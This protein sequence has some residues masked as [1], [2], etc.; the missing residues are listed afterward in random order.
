MRKERGSRH[1]LAKTV[2]LLLA[3]LMVLSSACSSGRDA[4]ISVGDG[5]AYVAAHPDLDPDVAAAIL[6][7]D[8]KAGMTVDEVLAAGGRPVFRTLYAETARESWLV[9]AAQLQLGHYRYHN[10]LMLR[11]VF[12]RGRVIAIEPIN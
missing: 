5:V 1:S 9:P 10:A 4:L 11:L 3:P 7:R 6:A 2:L 12:E 8:I